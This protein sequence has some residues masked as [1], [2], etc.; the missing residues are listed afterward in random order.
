MMN[1]EE[2]ISEARQ[3]GREDYARG[4]MRSPSVSVRC[5]ELLLREENYPSSGTIMRSWLEGWDEANL[6]DYSALRIS[7]DITE[8]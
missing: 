3:R 1:I 4:C 5:R 8:N 7:Q 6:K 2:L